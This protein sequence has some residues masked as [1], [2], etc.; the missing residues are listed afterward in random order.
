MRV[1]VLLSDRKKYTSFTALSSLSR[2]VLFMVF[3]HVS[4]TGNNALGAKV[5]NFRSTLIPLVAFATLLSSII[6][7][8][9]F[10]VIALVV[11]YPSVWVVLWAHET[12]L[13]A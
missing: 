2:L 5:N 9:H 8:S 3:L 1:T 4:P 12:S 11:N 13:S 10:T 6:G 7:F